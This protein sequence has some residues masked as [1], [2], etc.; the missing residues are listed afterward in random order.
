MNATYLKRSLFCL[1]V[2]LG[3]VM[4]LIA[5][6]FFGAYTQREWIRTIDERFL[7]QRVSD[8]LGGVLKERWET[9][10]KSDKCFDYS[11]LGHRGN[12]GPITVAHAMGGGRVDDHN[13]MVALKKTVDRGFTLVETDFWLSTDG[14]LFCFHG[15]SDPA[16]FSSQQIIDSFSNRKAEVC[17][18]SDVAEFIRGRDIFVILDLKTPFYETGRK[19]LDIADKY[20]VVDKLVFQLY[21]PSDV[22][23]FFEWS[24]RYVK[25]PGPIVT[26]YM[27]K[28]SL[29]TISSEI[30]R[31]GLR[32]LTFP[33]RLIH[34]KPDNRRLVY[35]VHPV[36]SCA[37]IAVL[38]QMNID[39]YY[40]FAKQ[41]CSDR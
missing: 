15:P 39:G 20:G 6:G 31:I 26:A 33:F 4:I 28:R 14:D 2:G 40:T 22:E 35:L 41:V 38:K 5:L 3:L 21:R 36:N 27:S 11:W 30:D 13:T 1:V 25:L 7:N 17:K 16:A 32:V 19:L 23:M 9:I 24:R 29:K 37:E 10:P 12:G 18:F 8:F 34:L